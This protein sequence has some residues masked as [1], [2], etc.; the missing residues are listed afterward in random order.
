MEGC[1]EEGDQAGGGGVQPVVVHSRYIH[2]FPPPSLELSRVTEM[3]GEHGSALW[4]M[5]E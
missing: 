3:C 4:P 5:E 1:R 2:V